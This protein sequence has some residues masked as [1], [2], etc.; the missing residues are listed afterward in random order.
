MR[1]H[2]VNIYLSIYHCR[3]YVSDFKAAKQRRRES[4]ELR[5]LGDKFIEEQVR[6]LLPACCTCSWY[7]RVAQSIDKH[8]AQPSTGLAGFIIMTS[9]PLH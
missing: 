9:P 8:A 3:R 1:R 6:D 4:D 5:F 2:S 7:L